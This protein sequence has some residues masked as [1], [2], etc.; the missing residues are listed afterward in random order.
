MLLDHTYNSLVLLLIFVNLFLGADR[1]TDRSSDL[2]HFATVSPVGLYTMK[3][4]DQTVS[5]V[6]LYDAFPTHKNRYQP[7][8]K[9]TSMGAS[10]YDTVLLH[11]QVVR[12][13]TIMCIKSIRCLCFLCNAE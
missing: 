3:P 2:L 8:I 7:S 5:Y 13:F 4:G 9:I 6:D 12:T 1:N 11:E 10:V